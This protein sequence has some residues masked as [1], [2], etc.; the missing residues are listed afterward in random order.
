MCL[1]YRI[2]GKKNELAKKKKNIW[3]K[4]ERCRLEGN[5]GTVYAVDK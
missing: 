1:G 3:P 5:G 2:L 4:S